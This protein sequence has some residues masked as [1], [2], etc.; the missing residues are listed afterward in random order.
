MKKALEAW[1]HWLL[2]S[3]QSERIMNWVLGISLVAFF[4][5]LIIQYIVMSC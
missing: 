5:K 3:E 2:V 4:G 1:G